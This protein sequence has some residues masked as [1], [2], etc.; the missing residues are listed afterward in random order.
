M[1]PTGYDAVAR[2]LADGLDVRL[3]AVVSRVEWGDDGVRVHTSAGV[4]AAAHAIVTLPLG[5]LKSG[6]VTFSPD[7]PAVNRQA[8][9]RLGMGLMNK[10]WLTFPR[11]FW[12]DAD[13]I[14][15][16]V[17]P[18]GRFTQFFAPRTATPM[19]VGFHTGAHAR[20]LER[21]SD[22]ET[23]AGALAALRATYGAD[24]PA[25][26]ETHVTRWSADP[27]ARGAY[28]FV[29]AGATPADRVALATP[30]GRAVFF[31]GEATHTGYPSTVHGAYLS[32]VA[33]AKA[34]R[35]AMRAAVHAA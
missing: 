1:F 5:V 9:E 32:G 27:F 23:V 31:A 17:D 13:W 21:R 12:G 34:V 2:A 22:D 14:N 4:L 18:V 25:P 35:R 10:V 29:A 7:L 30:L 16:A 28:S 24:V 11:R 6:A 19:L 26:V 3:G 33:A 15:R 8:V 20:D